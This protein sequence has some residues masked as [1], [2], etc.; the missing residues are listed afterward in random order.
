MSKSKEKLIVTNLF[1][2]I[3]PTHWLVVYSEFSSN[4]SG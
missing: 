4:R 3:V 2:D 1:L